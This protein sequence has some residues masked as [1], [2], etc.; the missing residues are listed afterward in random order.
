MLAKIR[1]LIEE[2]NKSGI[3]YCHWKSNLS[4]AKAL[5]GQTDID[6]LVHR[7]DAGLFR[8]ILGQQCFRPAI[9][10]DGESFPSVEHYYA[11]DEESGVLVHVHAY[12]RVITGES[13]AKNFRL[14]IE[15]ML[16]QNTRE[17]DSV[18]VPIQSAELVVFTMRMMLKHTSPME[19]VLLARYWKQVQ[20]EVEWLL[21]TDSLD[22]TLSF[23]KC[24]LPSLD[25]DLFSECVAALKSPA[26]LFRRIRLG[27]QLRSQLSPYARHSI[28]RAWLS[29]VQK[30]TKMF[31][32]RL[33]RSHKGMAPLG[34]GAVIAFVGSEA[35]GKSTLLAEMRGWLGEHFAVKQIHAGKPQS[36]L[37]SLVPNLLVPAL[38]SLLPSSRSTQVET[39]YASQE[40][41]EP[42]RSDYPL[43]FGI[44]SALLAYDRRSL[45]TRAFGRAANGTIVLCDRYPSMLSG[46][47]D[48][49]QLSHLPVSPSRYSVRR[50]LAR[51]EARLYRE[52]PPPDLVIYLSAPL[53]VT[54][55]RNAT[56]GKQEPEEYVRRRH[57]RSSN[58]EFGKTPVYKINTDQAFDQTVLEV[59]KAIWS[60]L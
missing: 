3:R 7:K 47:P 45:L 15:E 21:E 8:A 20:R 2:L 9:T 18:R 51:I 16:L 13:L 26:P 25:T 56:R 12:F 40:Q 6:L 60:A 43:I 48:S 46:A 5:A 28:L 23:V 59:K 1:D 17:V 35:T 27:Y 41:S 29:G 44:R 58:L 37:L 30:F 22:E 4:L 57:A 10:T 11:L 49:P 38:R 19:L 42:S 55:S 36:T 24:W 32:R 33:T 31:F 52:I 50:W 34:G 39:Q 14:P 54:V 53:E